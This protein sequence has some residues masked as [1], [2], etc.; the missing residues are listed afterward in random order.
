MVTVEELQD[1]I[2]RLYAAEPPK[3]QL[4]LD[5][6]RQVIAVY[7]CLPVDKI[8]EMD[9]KTALRKTDFAL[10]RPKLRT[11]PGREPQIDWV[12]VKK[13][14]PTKAS[15]GTSIVSND[16]K[17]PKQRKFRDKPLTESLRIKV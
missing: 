12:F 3:K 5:M 9:L 6:I 15:A 16:S 4:T 7:L 8:G 1:A 17:K 10:P 2:N 13:V 14:L 11:K